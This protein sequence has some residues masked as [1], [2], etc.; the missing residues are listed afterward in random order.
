MKK[1]ISLMVAAGIVALFMPPSVM[2][3]EIVEPGETQEFT[4]GDHCD[5]SRNTDT[6]F[7]ITRATCDDPSRVEAG[8]ILTIAA[9]NNDVTSFATLNT[10]FDVTSGNEVVLDATVSATV[11]WDGVLFGAGLLGAGASVKIE[12]FLVETRGGAVKGQTVVLSKSQDNTGLKGIDV[13]GTRVTGSREVSFTGAVVRGHEYSIQLK[14][15]CQA[16]SGLIGLEVGCIFF[17]DFFVDIDLGGDPHA[18]W[19]ELSITIEQDIFERL[20]EIAEKQIED[21][22]LACKPV[23]GLFLPE[24]SGGRAERVRTLVAERIDQFDDA[25]DAPDRVSK[26]LKRLEQ[27]DREF[28]AG[29]FKKAYRRYCSAYSA[30]ARGGD[31]DSK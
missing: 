21:N 8:A 10:N 31:D 24:S 6:P 19:T 18:K 29:R 16:E 7:E 12:M 13:G 22:L 5:L 9:L 27:G 11:D 25:I 20:D 26:A 4:A 2:A 3:R 1:F 28:D 15:T 14:L 30:I 17:N 23:V